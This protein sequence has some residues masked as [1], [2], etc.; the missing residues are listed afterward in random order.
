MHKKQPEI[1]KN[2][3]ELSKQVSNIFAKSSDFCEK[4]GFK[5]VEIEEILY[6]LILDRAAVATKIL[7]GVFKINLASL[8]KK[9]AELIGA[10]E[11]KKSS[12]L[13]S[14]GSSANGTLPEKLLNFG[15]DLTKKVRD[16]GFQ[17]IIGR[18]AETERVIEI[19]CRKTKN[20][21]V[22]LGEPGVGKTSVVEGLAQRI[23]LGDV[24]DI[25]LGKTI[26]ALD[27]ASL[28]SGTKFRGSL[29]QRLKDMISEI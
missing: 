23:E 7:G 16:K 3:I 20:N 2:E 22:L 18:D 14:S 29:E 8:E 13:A 17:K 12:S 24:P 25:L 5:V 27:L 10:D 9:L 11:Q 1:Q 15:E 21:P 26:F 6:F 19:L 28:V 4:K